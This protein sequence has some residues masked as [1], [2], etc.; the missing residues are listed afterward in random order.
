MNRD[1]LNLPVI[2]QVPMEL[3]LFPDKMTVCKLDSAD[4]IDLS[5]DLIFIGKT[6]GEISLVCPTNTVPDRTLCRE[7]GWRIFRI[8]G[9]LD[10]SLIG[11]ISG[12]SSVLA[13]EGIGIFV[14]STYDTDYFM[15]KEKDLERACDSLTSENYT[16]LR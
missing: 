8:Q 14:V 13:K 16:V 9:K 15:V 1:V 3:R 12:I 4:C 2:I 7:D 5:V 11:I 10:F 6:D